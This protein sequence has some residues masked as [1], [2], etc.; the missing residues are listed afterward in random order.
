MNKSNLNYLPVLI[1]IALV[2]GVAFLSDGRRSDAAAPT[3]MPTVVVNTTVNV[4]NTS[5][6][7]PT[8]ADS[9][10]GLRNQVGGSNLPSFADFQKQNPLTQ[11]LA[12]QPVANVQA[13]PVPTV[14]SATGLFDPTLGK[15]VI[16]D[17][18]S[19]KLKCDSLES[20]SEWG[21]LTPSQ[22]MIVKDLCAHL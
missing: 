3:P 17:G 13:A 16:V 14:A 11:T 21:S 8:L 9:L 18:L 10:A 22:Q 12:S 2:A 4:G 19:R 20:S 15:I 6:V 7:T 1:A 5:L